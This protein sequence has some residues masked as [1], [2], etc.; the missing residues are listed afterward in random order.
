MNFERNHQ[1]DTAQPSYIPATRCLQEVEA[2]VVHVRLQH[3]NRGLPC[4]PKAIRAYLAETLHICPLPSER[5]IARML[6]SN[7][8]THRRTA[9]YPGE[10]IQTNAPGRLGR[11]PKERR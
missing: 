6:R 3:Y 10:E 4:G 2:I 1:H 8:L 11:R 9:C 7:G 5:S